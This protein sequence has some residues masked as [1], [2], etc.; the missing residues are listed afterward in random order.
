[1]Q[2]SPLWLE[3]VSGRSGFPISGLRFGNIFI[4][5]QP[6]RGYGDDPSAV[7]HSPD[8]EPPHAYLT[9]YRWLRHQFDAHAVIQLGKHGNLEWL[10]GK[11]VALSEAC[12]PEVMLQDLP[13]IYPFIINN[14]G[15]GT[16][17][18]RRDGAI[19]VDHLIPPM[20]H[21]DT[22]GEL[23]E[24]EHLLDEYHSVQSLDPSKG[25]LIFERIRELVRSAELHRDL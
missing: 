13:N 12:Y 20:T 17:A 11:S 1:M 24:L 15:E 19:I 5:I 9:F 3:D 4:G 7:Y 25:P 10:P 22:Y 6:S 2:E 8:L 23:R 16:Q 14:P 21:A 18:K